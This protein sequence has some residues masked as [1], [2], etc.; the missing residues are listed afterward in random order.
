MGERESDEKTKEET[1]EEE[2]SKELGAGEGNGIQTE[3]GPEEKT[4]ITEV[5][6]TT[7]KSR[8]TIVSPKREDTRQGEAV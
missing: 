4:F 3:K 1:T 8:V 5:S 2:T 6:V 7:N